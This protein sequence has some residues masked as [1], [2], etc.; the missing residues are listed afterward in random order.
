MN[1]SQREQH[2]VNER[3]ANKQFAVMR[4]VNSQKVLREFESLSPVRTF[5]FPALQQA[6]KPLCLLLRITDSKPNDWKND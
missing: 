3:T 5:S 6:A 1:L 2:K 4:G